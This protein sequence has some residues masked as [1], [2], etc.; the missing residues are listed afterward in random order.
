MAGLLLSGVHV[1]SRVI[2]LN[3]A[4]GINGYGCS[5]HMV[6]PAMSPTGETSMEG[7]KTISMAKGFKR[8]ESF[9]KFLLGPIG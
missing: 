9:H 5:H 4:G 7:K 8:T 2:H 3:A 6:A 1:V